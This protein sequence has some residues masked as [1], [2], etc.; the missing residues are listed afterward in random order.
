MFA[1][2]VL[3]LIDCQFHY[4]LNVY[5]LFIV[6]PLCCRTVAYCTKSSIAFTIKYYNFDIIEYIS[7]L[8]QLEVLQLHQEWCYMHDRMNNITQHQR[9]M[10]QNLSLNGV[11][12][13]DS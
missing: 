9:S 11:Y 3:T 4:S 10:L 7:L 2:I 12:F 5:I 13:V 1:G 6:F 8:N